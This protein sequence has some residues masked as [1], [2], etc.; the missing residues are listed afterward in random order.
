[1]WQDL[2]VKDLFTL[3]SIPLLNETSLSFLLIE[4]HLRAGLCLQ[5]REGG[6]GRGKGREGK[7]K[8]GEVVKDPSRELTTK[9]E[10]E[11]EKS[12]RAEGG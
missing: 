9:R 11:K 10:G 2:L 8:E 5:V 6:E 12:S 7:E 4:D 1:M 3:E